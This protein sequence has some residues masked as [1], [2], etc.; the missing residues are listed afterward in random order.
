MDAEDGCV[1]YVAIYAAW[2][3]RIFL[4][5]QF[6]VGNLGFWERRVTWGG[7]PVNSKNFEFTCES[8]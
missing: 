2:I 5:M 7:K 1:V 3:M 4:E 8:R 6:W